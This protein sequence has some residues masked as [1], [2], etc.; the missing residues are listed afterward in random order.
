MK[1]NKILIIGAGLT[2]LALSH[3][4]RKNGLK[5]NVIE[6]SDRP[7]G[8]INTITGDGFTYET[9]PSTG[10]LSSFELVTLFDDL[11]GKVTLETAREEAKKRYILKNG[12][13]EPLPSG[14]FS[15]IGTPLFSMKDKFGILGEPFRKPGDDPDENVADMVV[16]RLGRSYLDYAVDPFISGVYAG[17]PKILVTRYAL[18][19][20]YALEHDH[21]SFIRGSVAKM[22]EP[23]SAEDR[24]VTKEVFSAEGG[25]G[26]LVN[27]LAG[28]A[29]EGSIK[30]GVSEVS[31]TPGADGFR[32][33]Y[34]NKKELVTDEIYS[35]V[36]T[37][38]GGYSLGQVLPFID[39]NL[40]EPLLQLRYAK[41]IQVAAGFRQWKGMKLDAFG[42]LV[43]G[44]EKQDILGILFPSA[45]FKNR[46]PENGALLSVFMGGMKRPDIFEMPDDKIYDIVRDVIKRTLKTGQ[47]PD[48]LKAFRYEHAIPQYEKST[49]ARLEA[50]SR[51]EHDYPGLIL[52]GNVRDGIGM[53]DRVKQAKKIADRI[54]DEKN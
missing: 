39:G 16:R 51:I 3:F 46:A 30:Y 35:D 7:G 8:V 21:G 6:K 36:V 42:A 11:K 38:S 44:K 53:S 18:P 31:V 34:R 27:A 13:W 4:L 5:S 19:K 2:G 24:R 45:I 40:L 28:E 29:D 22:K 54:K 9:G 14:L 32:V 25:L 37:T 49:G 20:L 23:K 41:V 48:L 47:S 10:V 15:A 12:R 52:A 1:D 43:P 17:D 33:S 26:S 50:I